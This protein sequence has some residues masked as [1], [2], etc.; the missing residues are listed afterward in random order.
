M[1][2]LYAAFPVLMY[3]TGNGTSPKYDRTIFRDSAATDTHMRLPVAMPQL[4]SD[5]ASD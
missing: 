2:W 5:V 1:A 3:M 4:L